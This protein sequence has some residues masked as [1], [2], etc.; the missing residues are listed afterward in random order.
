MAVAARVAG[1]IVSADIDNIYGGL[2]ELLPS[3]DILAPARRVR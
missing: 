1:V 3:I 2:S